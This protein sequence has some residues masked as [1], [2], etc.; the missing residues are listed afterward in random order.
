MRHSRRVWPSGKETVV[1]A[2]ET[3]RTL[4]QEGQTVEGWCVSW[5]RV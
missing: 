3:V 1:G 4:A 5:V 2:R